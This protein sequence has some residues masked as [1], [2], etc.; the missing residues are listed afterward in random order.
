MDLETGVFDQDLAAAT[1]GNVCEGE[2]DGRDYT[3]R[4][5]C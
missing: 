4:S 1:Q 2:H 5:A 3:S